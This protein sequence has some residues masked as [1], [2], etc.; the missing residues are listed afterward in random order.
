MSNNYTNSAARSARGAGR[1]SAPRHRT[2]KRMLAIALVA[3]STIGRYSDSSDAGTANNERALLGT[4]QQ[5][6][7]VSARRVTLSSSSGARKK[8]ATK[9]QADNCPEVHR[10]AD[11]FCHLHR[12]LARAS[13]RHRRVSRWTNEDMRGWVVES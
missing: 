1:T 5:Q 11:G 13:E 2:S 4:Q 12:D 9:C 6:Q 10:Y 8:P 7:Q 3:A